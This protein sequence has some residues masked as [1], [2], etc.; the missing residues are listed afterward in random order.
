[1][2]SWLRRTR[3]LLPEESRVFVL[4]LG[5]LVSLWVFV[6]L[7]STMVSGRTQAFD[8]QVLLAFRR[9]DD[10]ALPIGPRWC[11]AMALEVTA[12]GGGTVLLVIILL[13]GGYLAI[14]RRF[15]M[16]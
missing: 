3:A 10:R 12:L 13:V 7:A 2:A 4:A 6:A 11:Q 1:M 16:T 9:A 15:A 8:E 5:V 14:E